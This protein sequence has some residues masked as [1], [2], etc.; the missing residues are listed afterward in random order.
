MPA[1]LKHQ[2]PTPKLQNLSELK[3]LKASKTDST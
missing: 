3:C 1:G 2:K